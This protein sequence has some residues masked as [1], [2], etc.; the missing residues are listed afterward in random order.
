ML[1]VLDEPVDSSTINTALYPNVPDGEDLPIAP[2][3]IG[4]ID[5]PEGGMPAYL[6][7]PAVDQSKYRYLAAKGKIKAISKVYAY[8]TLVDASDYTVGQITHTQSGQVFTVID[9]DDDQRDSDRTEDIVVTWSGMGWVDSSDD[10]ITN[11][12]RIMEAFLNDQGF[13]SPDDSLLDAQATAV[14][15]RPLQGTLVVTDPAH[16]LRDVCGWRRNRGISMSGSRETEPMDWPC[17]S[18][19]SR[20]L[21]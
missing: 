4:E 11:P 6:I 16:T 20:T 10:A 7:D 15:A 19:V 2:I 5:L 21:W 12:I 14:A 18:R 13:T 9:F 3:L 17:P 8:G 1:T